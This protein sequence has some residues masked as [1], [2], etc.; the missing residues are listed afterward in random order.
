MRDDGIGISPDLLPH[1][2]DLFTQGKRTPDRAQGGL[3]L[4]LTLVRRLVE[5]HGGSVEARSEGEGKGSE[6]VVQLPLQG[7]GFRAQ[8]SGPEA[9]QPEARVAGSGPGAEPPT[10]TARA[11]APGTGHH[12]PTVNPEPSPEPSAAKRILLVEDNPD[13]AEVL[14]A[15]LEM[16]GHQVLVA[17]DGPAALNLAAGYAPDT[18]LMDIG[19]PGMNGHEVARRL[20]EHRIAPDA[21]LIALTGYGADEDV[22]RSHE[23]GFA[24]HLT[25]PVDPDALKQIVRSA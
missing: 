24:Y 7:S 19:L 12:P 9:A 10:A 15:I 25:K 22:R 20:R 17:H 11:P 13:A 21:V 2:F 23:A 18:V 5:M 8:G 3:G 6:F 4:G 16:D 1:V 14:A